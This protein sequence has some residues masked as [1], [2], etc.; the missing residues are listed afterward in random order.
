MPARRGW[1]CFRG[2]AVGR[3]GVGDEQSRGRLE[4]VKGRELPWLTTKLVTQ[5]LKSIFKKI[6]TLILFIF[7]IIIITIKCS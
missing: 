2:A 5:R 3:A 6:C 7:I 4:R 1:W